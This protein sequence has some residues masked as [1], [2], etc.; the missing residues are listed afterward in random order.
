MMMTQYGSRDFIQELAQGS[1]ARSQNSRFGYEVRNPVAKI[2][3]WPKSEF[4]LLDPEQA[5]RHGARTAYSQYGFVL[6]GSTSTLSSLYLHSSLSFH[7]QHL[8]HGGSGVH[9]LARKGARRG[10]SLLGRYGSRSKCG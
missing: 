10:G 8:A 6:F 7:M 4:W 9:C 5:L 1:K 3:P 2:S